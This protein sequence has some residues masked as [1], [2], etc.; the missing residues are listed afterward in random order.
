MEEDFKCGVI[1]DDTKSESNYNTRDEAYAYKNSL[2]KE[3]E[4][5]LFL[6]PITIENTK[7]YFSTRLTEEKT[8]DFVNKKIFGNYTH[9]IH[10]KK[11]IG[12]E[13]ERKELFLEEMQRLYGLNEKTFVVVVENDK[14]T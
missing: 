11:Y 12:I 1:F 7:L 14:N 2:Q 8:A 6:M 4:E 10:E 3:F 9:F 13:V 5:G